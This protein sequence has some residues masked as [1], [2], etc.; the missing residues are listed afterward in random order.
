[1]SFDP[2]IIKESFE[3]AKPIANDVVDKFYEFLWSD[4]PE[5][6]ALFD[7]VNMNHQKKALLNSLV[8][9]VENCDNT[10]K[11]IPYLEAMGSR[12]LNYGTQEEHYPI[13]GAT[14]LKT[15]EFFFKEKWTPELNEQWSNCYGVISSVMISGAKK[16]QKAA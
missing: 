2:K 4:Y 3:L 13:V 6:K 14:L 16:H 5:S 1:M 9:A 15:F 8:F 7:G 11:L 10:D 12:H